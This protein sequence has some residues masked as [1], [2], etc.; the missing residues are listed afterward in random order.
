M[1]FEA[2]VQTVS[3]HARLPPRRGLMQRLTRQL[4]ASG[5]SPDHNAWRTRRRQTR[6]G[7]AQEV[8]DGRDPNTW[9]DSTGASSPMSDGQRFLNRRE[10]RLRSVTIARFMVIVI[11]GAAALAKP[12]GWPRLRSFIRVPPGRCSQ[13]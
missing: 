9:A 11:T 2:R 10:R 7:V 3:P 4:A 1:V 5:W 6:A 8:L 12:L 13:V